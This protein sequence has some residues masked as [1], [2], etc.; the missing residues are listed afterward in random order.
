MKFHLTFTDGWMHELKHSVN[1]H[2]TAN[3]PTQHMAKAMERPHLRRVF[4]FLDGSDFVNLELALGDTQ[5][6]E[7]AARYLIQKNPDA[8]KR[9]SL[10]IKDGTNFPAY[11][12]CRNYKFLYHI[13][14]KL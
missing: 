1:A 9:Y 14:G 10:S 11:Q 12:A 5:Y 3:N 7:D 8:K 4:L 6:F 13:K 2:K